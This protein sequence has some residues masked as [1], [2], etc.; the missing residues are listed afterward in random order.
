MYNQE[1]SVSKLQKKTL[2]DSVHAQFRRFGGLV[3]QLSGSVEP[4]V[5]WVGSPVQSLATGELT[6]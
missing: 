1:N 2:I 5:W 3:P 6:H 4:T